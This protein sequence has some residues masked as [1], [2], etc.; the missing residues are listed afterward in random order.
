VF[1]YYL[2]IAIISLTSWKRV[3]KADDFQSEL[4]DIVR[5]F[6]LNI[7]DETKIKAADSDAENLIDDIDRELKGDPD[8]PTKLEELEKKV[9]ALDNYIEAVGIGTTSWITTADLQLG[10]Q[11]VGGQTSNV[12]TGVY[13]VDVIS[14]TV[15]NYMAYLFQNNSASNYVVDY[16]WKV[17]SG[18]HTGYGNMGVSKNEC[19]QFYNN[20]ENPN[21]KVINVYGITCKTF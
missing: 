1:K 5:N 20:R 10:N 17:K 2:I 21:D 7:M 12:S 3:S 18:T 8:D 14:V 11:L 13:C 6:K 15:G 16:K 19:R 9:T 4:D